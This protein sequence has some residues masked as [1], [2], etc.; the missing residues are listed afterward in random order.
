VSLFETE[1]M[2]ELYI[3][4]GLA[5]EGLEIYRRLAAQASDEP[6]RTR[7]RERIAE[8]E[9]QL[10]PRPEA[11]GAALGGPGL[12]VQQQGRELVIE[13]RLPPGDARQPAVQLLLLRRTEAGVETESRTLRLSGTRGSTTVDAPALHSLRAAAGWLDGDRFIPVVR[14][15]VVRG[16][17][18]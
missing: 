6:T 3:R 17:V 5:A 4:Q 9:A 18:V 1:T 14:G 13:W 15:D 7:W 11:G 16:D 10:G 12:R 2:A 8:L